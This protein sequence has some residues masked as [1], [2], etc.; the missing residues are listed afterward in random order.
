MFIEGSNEILI[1][2]G[3]AKTIYRKLSKWISRG[4]AVKVE[5]LLVGLWTLSNR[6]AIQN[7]PLTKK[8]IYIVKNVYLKIGMWFI[9]GS[10]CSKM[11]LIISFHPRQDSNR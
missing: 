5:F 1:K 11:L 7:T 4:L 2:I 3:Y 10:F 6:F 8:S 9:Q